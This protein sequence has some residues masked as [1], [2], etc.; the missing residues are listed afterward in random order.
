M[1]HTIYIFLEVAQK[2][3]EGIYKIHIYSSLMSF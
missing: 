3:L 2:L 1:Q